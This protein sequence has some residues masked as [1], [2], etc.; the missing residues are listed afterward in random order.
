VRS[1]TLPA[2]ARSTLAPSEPPFDR[3]D[4]R[5]TWPFISLG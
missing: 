3:D 5:R 2:S 4:E 1:A